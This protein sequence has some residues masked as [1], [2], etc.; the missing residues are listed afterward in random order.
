VRPSQLALASLKQYT[1]LLDKEKCLE[2]PEFH[3]AMH[4]YI[5]NLHY[6]SRQAGWALESELY[7]TCLEN[8][9]S[10]SLSPASSAALIFSSF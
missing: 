10:Q 2:L 7:K 9:N 6:Q 5:Q 4:A 8:P 1:S 3:K